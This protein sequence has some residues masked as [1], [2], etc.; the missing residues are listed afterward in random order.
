[1]NLICHRYQARIPRGLASWLRATMRTRWK[2]QAIALTCQCLRIQAL[3]WLFFSNIQTIDFDKC[4]SGSVWSWSNGRTGFGPPGK[5]VRI[6]IWIYLGQKLQLFSTSGAC[7]VLCPAA[8]YVRS[9]HLPTWAEWVQRVQICPLWT[10]QR[11]PPL[12]VKKV[13]MLKGSGFS[14]PTN[15]LLLQSQWKW[16]FIGKSGEGE[17]AV[18]TR[19]RCQNQGNMIEKNIDANSHLDRCWFIWFLISREGNSSTSLKGP[20]QQLVTRLL[21]SK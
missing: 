9:D 20:T 10:R 11:S 3:T 14:T 5:I 1:M 8:W 19:T 6:Y 7:A 16:W 4:L 2:I 21:V 13:R 18:E 17:E 12:P 15:P